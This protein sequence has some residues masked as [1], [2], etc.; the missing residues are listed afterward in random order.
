MT[1]SV[2]DLLDGYDAMNLIKV[3]G[4]M[5][6]PVCCFCKRINVFWS[7]RYQSFLRIVELHD[8]ILLANFCCSRYSSIYPE[9]TAAYLML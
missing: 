8:G 2:L 9:S 3:I 6:S 1:G 7:L 4:Q 5:L